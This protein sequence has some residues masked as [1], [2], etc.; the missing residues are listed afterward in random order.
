MSG[1]IMVLTVEKRK[2]DYIMTT[3]IT[4]A[5]LL[6]QYKE[7]VARFHSSIGESAEVDELEMECVRL[8]GIGAKRGRGVFAAMERIMNEI[9]MEL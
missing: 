2:K 3:E 8:E 9:T 4:T 5:E 1:S 7:A 6:E